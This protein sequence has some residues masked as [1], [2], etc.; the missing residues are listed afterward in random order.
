MSKVMGLSKK[1]TA[2][3]VALLLMLSVIAGIPFSVGAETS[4]KAPVSRLVTTDKGSYVEYKGRPYLMYGV[5]MRLDFIYAD[6]QGDWQFIEENFKKAKEDGFTTVAIPFHWSAFEVSEGNFDYSRLT[7]YYSYLNKYDLKVQWLWFG[8]NVCGAAYAPDYI[9]KSQSLYKQVD[10]G[11]GYAHM[12]FSCTDTL[13]KEKT[14][15]KHFIDFIA[16]NDTEQRCVMIQL[17]NELDQSADAFQKKD[18]NRLGNWWESTDAHDE[19]CWVGGQKAEVIKHISELGDI[20][21][22]SDYSV[23]TRVNISAAGRNSMDAATNKKVAVSDYNDLLNTTGIDIVGIDCYAKDNTEL[24]GYTENFNNNLLH[25][26]EIGGCVDTTHIAASLFERG[27]GML[28]YAHRDDR[29]HYGMYESDKTGKTWVDRESTPAVRNF[30]KMI[31]S[32]EQPLALAVSKSEV[33][34]FTGNGSSNVSDDTTVTVSNAAEDNV[35]MAFR[36]DKNS[37]VLLSAKEASF[38]LVSP[39]RQIT[40]F[41]SGKYVNGAFIADEEQKLTINGNTVTVGAN[42]VV[43]VSVKSNVTYSAFGEEAGY[44]MGDD[45]KAAGTLNDKI[46]PYYTYTDENQFNTITISKDV[47]D[48]K[49]SF[50]FFANADAL[51]TAESPLAVRVVMR[52]GKEGRY[53]LGLHSWQSKTISFTSPVEEENI[54]SQGAINTGWHTVKIVAVGQRMKIMIDGLVWKDLTLSSELSGELSIIMRKADI[55]ELCA[56]YADESDF[57]DD[58]IVDWDFST[59]GLDLPKMPGAKNHSTLL[60][61]ADYNSD[62]FVR[63]PIG[64]TWTGTGF[65]GTDTTVSIPAD[66]K[67]EI[68]FDSTANNYNRGFALALPSGRTVLIG[69]ECIRLYASGAPFKD[70]DSFKVNYE[71]KPFNQLRAMS[72]SLLEQGTTLT[73]NHKDGFFHKLKIVSKNGI[74]QVFVDNIL[75]FTNTVDPN[76]VTGK[77]EYIGVRSNTG[78][79]LIESIKVTDVSEKTA[80]KAIATKIGYNNNRAGLLPYG[81]NSG[82]VYSDVNFEV[83]YKDGVRGVKAVKV[84]N[85]GYIRTRGFYDGDNPFSTEENNQNWCYS[86]KFYI[87][88]EAV[89]ADGA[90]AFALQLREGSPNDGNGVYFTLNNGNYVIKGK[91][92]NQTISTESLIEKWV[93]LDIYFIGNHLVIDLDGQKNSFTVQKYNEAAG[94]SYP[95]DMFSKDLVQFGATAANNIWLTD[96]IYWDITELSNAVDA[97]DKVD[98]DNRENVVYTDLRTAEAAY[99]ALPED[100]KPNVPN[101]DALASAR[102]LLASYE[103]G[104]VNRDSAV[105]IIDLIR[106]KKIS[107]GTSEPTGTHDVAGDGED[108]VSAVDLAEM[109]IILLEK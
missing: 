1:I 48:F 3:I 76:F 45:W 40:A 46:T 108:S 22:N 77:L 72:T 105:D 98:T 34:S 5:Q 86:V 58:V 42:T 83:G 35:A 106:L 9:L 88:N 32:V 99:T 19:Y 28:I 53:V 67:I 21:H 17:N 97:I 18:N 7:T 49:L 104:D 75:F 41:E 25:I 82:T 36:A 37:Y 91:G 74:E 87:E 47:K 71:E 100:E 65:N 109:R 50:K 80:R 60:S 94:L 61:L 63:Y 107:V 101:A 69:N 44:S 78:N 27:G 95:R 2:S 66:N 90:K 51:T 96:T 12:D 70:W 16:E 54:N 52:D 59:E 64:V 26:A 103:K 84:N 73:S 33:S 43:R 24:T 23:V 102:E 13:E 31:S 85:N 8:S 39:T 29:E 68:S 56:D 38:T 6:Y 92:L 30:S 62:D 81:F 89:F 14:A 55:A 11:D 15:F 20:V 10:A 4:V 93:E 79:V 57:D